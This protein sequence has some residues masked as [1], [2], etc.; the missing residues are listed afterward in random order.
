MLTGAPFFHN[1]RRAGE[2]AER[3]NAPVLKTGMGASPSWVRIPPS[4]PFSFIKFSQTTSNSFA[5][6][7]M[8]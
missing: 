3:L 4:P 1:H 5:E 6:L 7:G 8:R 2:V